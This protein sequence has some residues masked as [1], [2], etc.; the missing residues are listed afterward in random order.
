MSTHS[1]IQQKQMWWRQLPSKINF[2]VQYHFA[3]LVLSI[4]CSAGI[5]AANTS[6]IRPI[7]YSGKVADPTVNILEHE[8]DSNGAQSDDGSLREGKSYLTVD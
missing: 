4:I 2:A 7:P 8:W 6:P 3:Y 1:N 5:L